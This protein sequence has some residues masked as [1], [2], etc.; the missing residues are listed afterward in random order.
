MGTFKHNKKRDTGLVYEF[1]VRK[2]SQTMVEKDTSSYQKTMD[3]LRKYYGDGAI[4]AEERELFDVIMNARGLSEVAARRVL[5]EVQRVA[6][7]M[8]ARKIDI[9][10]SNLIKEI[11][12]TFGRDFFSNHRV[13]T[14]R[15]LASIQMLSTPPVPRAG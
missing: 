13:P 15:L 5:G 6:K 1:L 2:L 12:Y 14:Y 9:K 4:L 8:D 11:N 10:K 7:S 3:I